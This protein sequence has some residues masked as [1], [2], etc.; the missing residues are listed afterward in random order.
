VPTGFA[1]VPSAGRY[2]VA[3]ATLPAV[4]VETRESLPT[5]DDGLVRADLE[6]DGATIAAILPPSV[7][8][9]RIS[10]LD[11]AGGMVWPGFVDMHTHI[12]KGHIW[13][14]KANPDGTFFGALEAVRADRRA[15]WSRTD[16]ARRMDFSLRCAYAH[17]TVLLRTHIDSEAPQHRISW[18]VFA[19]MRDLWAGRIDLQGVSLIPIEAARDHAYL[20]ALGSLVKDHGGVFGCV[21]YMYPGIDELLD[22]VFAVAARNGL[23]LD[24]HSDESQDPAERSLAHVAEAV[25]RN[26]FPGRVV[27]GHCCSLLR[28]PEQ[29][30]AR[31]IA[32]V[33]EAGIAVVSLPL[34]NMYLQDRDGGRTPLSRGITMLHELAAAGVEI[35][36]ASDNTRDPFYAYGDLDMLEV[37]RETIRIAQF[38]HP[39]S[40][41]PDLVA[42]APGRILDRAD[43]G[44]VRAGAPADLILFRGRGWTELLS[45]PQSDRTVLRGGR[46]ID[47]TLPDFRELD[48]L[49]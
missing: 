19:E 4:L 3:N 20:D 7:S 18:P 16:V 22:R 42:A 26:R 27:C 2:L 8:D 41:A 34:C 31:T 43:R 24:F 39:I 30:A 38:D 29:E 25:I 48:D 12:D 40:A 14:R 32:R 23:D 35:A 21:T 9:A 28:Q 1:N 17:G 13:P 36:V 49:F 37:F 6:I 5:V 10:V 45:R 33:R 44:M 11:Q 47:T 46:P 15:N